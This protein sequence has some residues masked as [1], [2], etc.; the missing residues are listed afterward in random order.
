M[1][2]A[3]LVFGLLFFIPFGFLLAIIFGF[4]ALSKIKQ[5]DGQLGGNGM[6]IAGIVLGFAWVVLIIPIGLLAAMAI[7]AFNKVRD[8][9]IEKMVINDGRMIGPIA[10]M[11]FM[12][13]GAESV[14]FATLEKYNDYPLLSERTSEGNDSVIEQ[15]GTFELYSPELDR[16]FVFD[17]EGELISGAEDMSSY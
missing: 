4:I 9:S 13:E 3:S 17:A 5:S 7:P 11:Y 2:I 16:T 14:D 15:D 10:Q 12:D 1:A 6:A 8:V